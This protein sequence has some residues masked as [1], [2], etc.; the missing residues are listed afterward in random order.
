M[1]IMHQATLKSEV[2]ISGIGVHSGNPCSISIFPAPEDYGIV[3]IRK[4]VDQSRNLIAAN[5]KNVSE[6]TMC[7]KLSNKFEVSISTVEHLSAAFYSLGITNAIVKADSEEIP[8]M[9]GSAFPFVKA[10]SSAGIQMQS[11]EKKILHITRTIKIGDDKKWAALSP[12]DS[13]IINLECDFLAKGLRTDP[14][15]YNAS[16]DNFEQ[17][18][19]AARSFGFFSDAEYLRKNNLALGASLENAVVFGDHGVPMN[20]NGLRYFNE[21][22]RHKILDIIGDL[23]LAQHE[24]VG[25]YDGFCPG[26]HLNNL[27]LIE[28]FKEN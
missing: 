24:I 1:E 16:I 7:T 26:H 25:R 19:A 15:S 10:I 23:S 11:K 3:Y 4:D 17:D 21:P 8:I 18:I 27:L 9:D 6:T 12:S 28:L 2:S 5:Y 22:I 13:F 20:K 14:F